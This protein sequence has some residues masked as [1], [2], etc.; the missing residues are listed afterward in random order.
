MERDSEKTAL[1]KEITFLSLRP[2]QKDLGTRVEN[3]KKGS[4]S[5][6]TIVF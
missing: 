3:T 5:G 2:W 4:K 6:E 1:E